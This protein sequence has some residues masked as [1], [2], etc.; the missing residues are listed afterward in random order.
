MREYCAATADTPPYA[1]MASPDSVRDL[2]PSSTFTS[3]L[4]RKLRNPAVD[5]TT[6]PLIAVAPG[7]LTNQR[8][9]TLPASKPCP[10]FNVTLPC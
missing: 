10:S 3:P 6:V 5:R 4:M 2:P 7:F 9:T 8:F 1:I